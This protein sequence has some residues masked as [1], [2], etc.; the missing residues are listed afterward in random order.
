MKIVFDRYRCPSCKTRCEFEVRHEPTDFAKSRG[1]ASKAGYI[2]FFYGHCSCGYNLNLSMAILQE[3]GKEDP[4]TGKLSGPYPCLALERGYVE[5]EQDPKDS[6]KTKT[7]IHYAYECERSR[8]R[9]DTAESQM[10]LNQ[11]G[12]E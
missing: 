6:S 11:E 8:R 10:K 5:Q 3:F 7:V 12:E 9:I 4:Y 2:D 1:Y